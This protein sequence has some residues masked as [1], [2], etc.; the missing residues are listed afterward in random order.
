MLNL[1]ELCQSKKYLKCISNTGPNNEANNL[2]KLL[3]G[4][5]I[6]SSIITNAKTQKARGVFFLLNQKGKIKSEYD[7][8]VPNHMLFLSGETW[9]DYSFNF[10]IFVRPC[11]TVPRHG[12]VDSVICNDSV[13]LNEISLLTHEVEPEAEI[14]ITKP[15]DCHYNA[16]INGDVITFA[17]DNDG[18][19]AGKGCK[20]FYL[21]ED[22]VSPS[23]QLND[24]LIQEG[25]VP[26][27]ELVISKDE[28]VN[29][30]QV[31]SAPGV[32][33]AKDYVPAKVEIKTIIR[34]E[35]D[36]LDWELKL[37]GIDATTTII[38]HTGGSLSSHYAIHAIVNKIPI[39]TTYLPEVGDIIEPTV[40]DKELSELDKDN[41]YKAFVIGFNSCKYILENMKFK[42]NGPYEYS[43]ILPVMRKV[44]E[45]SLATLHNFSAIALNRDYEL[46]G[47]VL[48]L[49]LRTTFAVSAGEARYLDSKTNMLTVPFEI[50]NYLAKLPRERY[51]AYTHMFKRDAANSIAEISTIYHIFRDLKWNGSFGGAKWANCTL[52]SIELFNACVNKEIT[53]VVELFN[54]VINEEHNGGKYLNKVIDVSMFDSAA[55]FPSKFALQQLSGIIDIVYTA[56]EY[57]TKH[58]Q[59]WEESIPAFTTIKISAAK[60]NFDKYTFTVNDQQYSI[61]SLKCPILGGSSEFYVESCIAIIE[62]SSGVT[63]KYQVDLPN[64]VPVSNES[65]VSFGSSGHLRLFGVPYAW[66]LSNELKIVDKGFLTKALKSLVVA[67]NQ[68]PYIDNSIPGCECA[69]CNPKPKKPVT[70]K[71]KPIPKVGAKTYTISYDNMVNTNSNWYSE[72]TFSDPAVVNI[73]KGKVDIVAN[74]SSDDEIITNNSF[75]DEIMTASNDVTESKIDEFKAALDDLASGLNPDMYSYDKDTCEIKKVESDKTE[76]SKSKSLK[77]ELEKIMIKMKKSGPFPKKK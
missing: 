13:R 53:K 48:G 49:F 23:I 67:P 68:T 15:I 69:T 22:V 34:A 51:P 40:E 10:P 44:L 42:P 71:S 65:A 9:G 17:R 12:F 26:F 54:R 33:R 4:G 35:G 58:I 32:P 36:L 43:H 11:P 77:K 28:V 39:F 63:F 21:G 5:F 52:S 76:F 16:I 59:E 3:Q 25:E 72:L 61:I 20:Y 45:L 75:N 27:Y 7:W 37:K 1:D 60:K 74:N 18:A 73:V 29:L 46:L 8:C 66:A 30:V 62:N 50:Q 55:N 57:G 70:I 56:W 31:R 38:N 19:T 24:E 47:L 41:F 14:L 64:K 6:K 2:N